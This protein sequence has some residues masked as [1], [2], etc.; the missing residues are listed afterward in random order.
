MNNEVPGM[1]FSETYYGPTRLLIRP[2]RQVFCCA[3][4]SDRNHLPDAEIYNGFMQQIKFRR[5]AKQ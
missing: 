3:D 4:A 5:K 1:I 2:D